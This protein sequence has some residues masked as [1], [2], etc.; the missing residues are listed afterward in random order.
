MVIQC[1]TEVMKGAFYSPYVAIFG[2]GRSYLEEHIRDA[3]REEVT[4]IGLEK[5][6]GMT[7]DGIPIKQAQNMFFVKSSKAL[8]SR[9]SIDTRRRLKEVSRKAKTVGTFITR[10]GHYE[11]RYEHRR[12]YEKWLSLFDIS[13][14]RF[15][16]VAKRD[17]A[18]WINMGPS[19]RNVEH[20]HLREH[21]AKAATIKEL[22]KY[23]VMKKFP[24][25]SMVPSGFLFEMYE[26][27]DKV[28]PRATNHHH[29]P[30]Y[31]ISRSIRGDILP[32][33]TQ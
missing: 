30:K 1:S 10:Q 20:Y 25:T 2:G 22:E 6:K 4:G 15:N 21:L 23:P 11:S 26:A 32:P 28:F 3:R 18:W 7:E 8:H 5:L 16:N 19:I 31:S 12:K 14:K 24:W 17:K 29:W 33:L 13:D 9:M 27:F